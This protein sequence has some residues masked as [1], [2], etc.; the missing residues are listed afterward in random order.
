MLAATLL[1]SFKKLWTK[2]LYSDPDKFA[3][4]L[5]KADLI[6]LQKYLSNKNEIL[7]ISPQLISYVYIFGLTTKGNN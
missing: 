3:W 5:S 7:T 6:Y 4:N 1:F 2:R